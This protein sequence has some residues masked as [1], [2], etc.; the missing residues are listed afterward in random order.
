MSTEHQFWNAVQASR[1]ALVPLVKLAQQYLARLPEIRRLVDH[2][3]RAGERLNRTRAQ[4]VFAG[5]ERQV[6]NFYKEFGTFTKEVLASF[7][8]LGNILPKVEVERL[9]AEVHPSRIAATCLAVQ[10]AAV[11][12]EEF[13]ECR[14]DRPG[15]PTAETTS[16]AG[17]KQSGTE[18]RHKR[19]T[20]GDEEWDNVR[21]LVRKMHDEGVT[22]K[23]MCDRLDQMARPPGAKWRTLSWRSAFKNPA[24]K[25]AVKTALSKLIHPQ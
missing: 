7:R 8:S 5:R 14:P 21:T 25:S 6:E 2:R 24:Y 12:V 16:A 13:W 1:D 17:G 10:R 22:H 15:A 3:D 19:R 18:N 9:I 11:R 23:D 20:Q 4:I